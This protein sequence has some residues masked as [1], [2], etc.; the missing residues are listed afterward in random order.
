M[1]LLDDLKKQ[2]EAVRTHEDVQRSVRLENTQA[3]EQAMRQAFR[4]LYDVLEQLKVIKPTNP[5][6]YRMPGIGE[7]CDLGFTDSFAGSREKRGLDKPHLDRIDLFIDWTSKQDLIVERDMPAAADKV[8]NLLWR[9]GFKFSEDEVKTPQGLVAL[10]RFKIPKAIRM[11]LTVRADYA[12]R[13]L[14]VLAKNL[15][16]WGGDEFSIPA[17]DCSE[18]LFEDMARMLI[19]QP[20]EIRRYRT[21][22]PADSWLHQN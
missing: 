14:V 5:I 11:V 19:G 3:V 16:R 1:G 6:V 20:S 10:T 17:D 22:L 15:L 9:T 4:Y 21:V 7:M 13:R 2:A 8:R 18:K 12:E